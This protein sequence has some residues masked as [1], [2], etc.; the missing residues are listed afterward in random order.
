MSELTFLGHMDLS[1]NNLS[2]KIP[3]STQLQNCEASA[4]GHNLALCGPPVTPSCLE[5]KTPEGQPGNHQRFIVQ[6]FLETGLFSDLG[7]LERLVYGQT[8]KKN[9]ES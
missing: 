3:S 8:R 4:F 1:Y 7:Q 6:A 5:A 9:S 2:G